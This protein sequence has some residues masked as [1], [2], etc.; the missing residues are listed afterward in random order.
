MVRVTVMFE[1]PPTAI[2]SLK[3]RLLLLMVDFTKV[4]VLED[5][6]SIA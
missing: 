1:N 6:D 5:F 4:T 3:L 2:L